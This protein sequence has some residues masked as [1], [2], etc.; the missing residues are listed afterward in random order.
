MQ[1]PPL[2][3]QQ[4]PFIQPPKK[5]RTWLWIITL[6]VV[7]FVGYG[8]GHSGSTAS[9][10]TTTT[11][12]QA[13]ST[14]PGAQDTPQ[15]TVKPKTWTVTHTFTG[16]GSKKTGTFSVPS[17][18]KITWSCQETDGIDAQ[19]FISIYN[20]D[21]TP[22]DSGP[23]TTCKASGPKTTGETEEHQAGNVYLDINTAI[24]WSI[25]IQELK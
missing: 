24:P 3:S 5:S 1:Q 17:D 22:F 2:P 25:S 10:D 16:N 12:I 4:P 11:N 19:L 21:A 23:D 7:F 20:S 13:S 14:T 8:A 6:I 9:T 15:A 18:W